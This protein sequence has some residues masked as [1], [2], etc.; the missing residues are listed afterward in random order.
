MLPLCIVAV[1][2]PLKCGSVTYIQLLYLSVVAVLW[3]SIA[4]PTSQAGNADFLQA[5]G[6]TSSSRVPGSPPCRVL[7]YF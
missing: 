1:T 5:L 2:L 7:F 3:T 6:V 4:D